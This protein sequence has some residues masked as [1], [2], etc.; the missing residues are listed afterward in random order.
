MGE[1]ERLLSRSV[2]I[3]TAVDPAT[4]DEDVLWRTDKGLEFRTSYAD[5]AVYRGQP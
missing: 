5:A 2:A 1:F 3:G 4:G